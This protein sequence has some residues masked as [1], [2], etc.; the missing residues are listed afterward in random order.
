MTALPRLSSCLAGRKEKENIPSS[1]LASLMSKA[2]CHFLAAGHKSSAS[3]I[4]MRSL[5]WRALNVSPP[6]LA[7]W[8]MKKTIFHYLRRNCTR[9]RETKWKWNRFAIIS[10]TRR[11]PAYIMLVFIIH[12]LQMSRKGSNGFGMTVRLT[13]PS[14]YSLTTVHTLTANSEMRTMEG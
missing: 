5:R 12:K 1:S 13:E 6:S 7:K 4:I 8:V 2:E 14:V 9:D 3:R 11:H 10:S